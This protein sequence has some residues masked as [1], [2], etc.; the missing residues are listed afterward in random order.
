VVGCDAVHEAVR[1]PIAGRGVRPFG[2]GADSHAHVAVEPVVPLGPP[3]PVGDLIDCHERAGIQLRVL[4]DLWPF[5]NEVV[6]TTVGFS[7]IRLRNA[8]RP[9]PTAA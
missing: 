8:R 9:P 6:T 7:G 1:V 3:E 4:P 2:P 5:W